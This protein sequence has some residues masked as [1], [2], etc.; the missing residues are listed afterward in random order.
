MVKP[1]FLG[2]L[3]LHWCPAC[4]VP[5]LDEKCACGAQTNFVTVTPPADIRPAFPYDINRINEVSVRQFGKKMIADGEIAVYNKAPYDDR[6]EEIIC[7][8]EVIGTIRFEIDKPGWVLLPRLSGARRIFNANAKTDDPDVEKNLK[9]WI[10]VHEK[11]IPFVAE[12]SSVLVPGI[13]RT[14]P[15][16]EKEDEIVVVTPDFEVIAT[17]RAKMSSEE[18]QNSERGKAVKIRWN[19]KD[20]AERK[21]TAETIP[22]DKEIPDG[23]QVREI[24]QKTIDANRH[25]I[26]KFEADS[27][28][29]MQNA[30]NNMNRKLTCSYSGGKDSLV[31]LQLT[32]K[33]FGKDSGNERDYEIIFA[34]TGLEFQETIDNVKEVVE[35]YGKPFKETSAGNAFWEEYE[36]NG[37]PSVDNRWCTQSCKLQPITNVIEMN[38]ADDGGCMTF[39]GQRQYESKARAKSQRIWKSPSVR[40]Q[41]GAA[42]IQEWTAMH[43]W[44]Y[45]FDQDLHYNPLY[46]KGLDRIG[47]WLCPAAS[48]ADFENLKTTHPEAMAMWEGKLIEAGREKEIEN[49][50]NWVKFGLWRY[51]KLPPLMQKLAAEKGVK[52]KK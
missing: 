19:Q 37:P 5:V 11:A 42:P 12:G 17:G 4:N 51:D 21:I 23:T 26:D 29:F 25:V 3:V 14:A 20:E 38:Y 44:L 49:P 45:I 16:F 32:E 40:G 15:G 13:L 34:D 2:K 33:A 18:I 50:E 31:T 24:W 35:I 8:G 52:Y 28:R 48:L 22:A 27:I 36:I 39:I 46:E 30:A 9:N 6:M 10:M 41:I 7:G 43:V 1:V 47:C